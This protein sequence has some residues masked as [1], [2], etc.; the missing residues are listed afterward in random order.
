MPENKMTVALDV[1]SQPV[2]RDLTAVISETEGFQLKN[3]NGSGPYDVLILEI[4]DDPEKDFSLIRSIQA[5]G[6]AKALFLTSSRL[7]PEVLIRALRTGAKEF[8]PQPIQK[9]DLTRALLK[10]QEHR[11]NEVPA[12]GKHRQGR[13]IHV[14]GGKGGVGTTTVA[15]N[16]STS[17][18]EANP[19]QSVALID[20]NLLFGEIP[21]FLDL[22]S[23]FDWGEVVKDVGRVDT[24]F[25]KSILVKHASGI[26][27]LPS[28]IALGGV[29]VATPEVIEKLLEVMRESFD[30]IVI[31]GGQSLDDISLKILEMSDSLL[32]VA[33][34]SLPCLTNVKRLLWTF[35]R[36]GYPRKEGIRV[37]INR[38]HK[39]S[40]ISL[41]EAEK[42]L[43]QKVFWQIPND[44]Q[45]TMSA[46]NQ[47]K[48]LSSVDRASEVCRNFRSL[49]SSFTDG[50]EQGT[51]KKAFWRKIL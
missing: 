19:T 37:V 45:T 40:L 33:I 49:A 9:E 25:L 50:E 27:V 13:I 39:N 11:L 26:F 1:K 34:L 17:L 5:A 23:D 16:L 21:I 24:T 6:T 20:M 29:N 28:P 51:K 15:V 7:E 2:V 18:A 46:I 41:G 22:Q 38:Y 43:G 35:E 8:L 10:Y 31:D 14:M 42:S 48:M 12:T 47:G 3:L 32:M 36:L 4:G 44:F 30:F